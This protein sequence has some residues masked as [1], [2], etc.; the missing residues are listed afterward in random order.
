VFCNSLIN[1][2]TAKHSHVCVLTVIL[3]SS[4]K[5][6]ANRMECPSSKC[7]QCTCTVRRVLPLVCTTRALLLISENGEEERA[8]CCSPNCNFST[9]CGVESQYLLT[10]RDVAGS[11][12]RDRISFPP[13]N[14]VIATQQDSELI[15][16][17]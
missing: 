16:T 8:A 6:T 5:S 12:C 15:A 10:R 7:L 11:C 17:H 1:K 4:C 9:T 14:L 3:L 13:S 2:T